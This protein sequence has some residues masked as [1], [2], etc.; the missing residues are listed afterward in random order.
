MNRSIGLPL[1]FAVILTWCIAPVSDAACQEVSIKCWYGTKQNFGNLGHP[2]R[3]VNVLGNISPGDG[4]SSNYFILNSNDPDTFN[5]GSDLH[6]LAASGDFNIQLSWEDLRQGKNNLQI[7]VKN[8]SGQ[9]TTETIILHIEKEN[10]WPLPY[11][12]D[13][14][15]VSALQDVVQVVDG[16]WRLEKSGVRTSHRYYDRVLTL[17]D[18]SWKNYQALIKLTIHDW[19][20]SEPGPPTYNVSHMGVALRWRG[21]HEDGRQP[22]RK[23]Y[24]L[25]AQGEFLLKQN[26][27]SCR[28]RIL[29]DGTK[30]K[31]RKYA[32]VTNKLNPGA[33]IFI[34][35]EVKTI[36]DGRSR[37]RFKQWHAEENEPKY[38]DVSGMEENDYPSGA[39][40]LV[41][42]N[43]DVTIHE[44]RV[45][46]LE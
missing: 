2:Q 20:P 1:L 5:L 8:T 7:I 30:D 14:S 38:W 3:W 4:V 41:P 32:D 25:G 34:R 19:T 35:A 26:T 24:P 28:W 11:A 21:H 45:V 29:F 15:T 42:H 44:I 23:W 12:I 10:R 16:K 22:S 27:D 46:P 18:S 31:K 40:C 17:G 33:P 6:R 37:Y 13:F 9:I 36:L 43:S 39:L